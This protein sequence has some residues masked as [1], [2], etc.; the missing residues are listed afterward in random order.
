MTK[1]LNSLPV[2]GQKSS[3]RPPSI[4]NDVIGPVMRGPSSSHCAAA[5]R[6]GRLARDLMGGVIEE[7]LVEFHPDGSLATT[8]RSQGSDMGLFGGL[9]GWD[10][11]H[12]ELVESEAALAEAGIQ[13]TIRI[14]EF[15]AFH[16]N[17]YRMTLS[18]QNVTH[19][20]TALSTGGG[21]IEVA[22]IDGV[23]LELM[24]DLHETLV[25]DEAVLDHPGVVLARR[26]RRHLGHR[27]REQLHRLDVAPGP[28]L[29]GHLDDVDAVRHLI[30]M[31]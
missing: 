18:G 30:G 6:I 17:T 23:P 27:G 29:V 31:R 10:A 13:C 19:R 4:F 3:G 28:A 14:T 16:P 22:E 15:P 5:V 24:G 7:I 12:E 8:H 11:D 26:L 2:M 21:I 20:M 9:L 1:E 25:R